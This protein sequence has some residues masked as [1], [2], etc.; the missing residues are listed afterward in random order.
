MKIFL[1]TAPMHR[2]SNSSAFE[3][4]LGIHL[5]TQILQ[6]YGCQV[7]VFWDLDLGVEQDPHELMTRALRADLICLSATSSLN[8]AYIKTFMELVAQAGEHPP[9]IVGGVHPTLVPQH[10]MRSSP[11]DI[12]VVGEGERAICELVDHFR[13]QRALEDIKGIYY[14]RNG[15]ILSTPKRELLT[16]KELGEL[17]VVTW[18]GCPGEPTFLPVQT[19]R[20]CLMDCKFCAVPFHRTWRPFPVPH[21]LNSIEACVQVLPGAGSKYIMFADDCF[22]ANPQIAVAVLKAITEQYSQ[23][24]YSL[25]ARVRDLLRPGFLEIM[26]GSHTQAISIGVECGYDEGLRKITKGLKIAEVEELGRLAKSV[27][28]EQGIHYA[29]MIGFPW[30]TSAEIKTTIDFAF[31]IASRYGGTLQIIWWVTMPGNAFFKQICDT[32]GLDD[33]VFD[34]PNWG[35][36]RAMFLKTHPWVTLDE[37]Y[38]V[39]DYCNSLAAAHKHIFKM[40]TAF[41]LPWTDAE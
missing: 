7:D 12:V 3:P 15:E 28:V 31:S 2:K 21:I 27:G 19:S 30:E 29:Y 32:Y 18:N 10:V 20:G 25:H 34:H 13:G 35:M 22:T 8:W 1:A 14:R 5:L 16:S 4:C 26:A 33:T 39:R 24:R 17:P 36:S 11:A 23:V 41:T 6:D 38:R 37:V 40:G 9:L